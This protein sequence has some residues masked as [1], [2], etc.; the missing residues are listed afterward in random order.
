MG[1][2]TIH[3]LECVLRD[4]PPMVSPES[5]RRVMEAYLAADLSAESGEPVSLPLN[6][7]ALSAVQELYRK[8]STPV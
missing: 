4:R 8:F 1:P 7:Q 2:E 3:F 6:N 5:A